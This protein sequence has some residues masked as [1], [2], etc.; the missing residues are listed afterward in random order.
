[1]SLVC[2]ACVAGLDELHQAFTQVRTGTLRDVGI[3]LAGGA[4]ALGLALAAAALRR[5][6]RGGA[7]VEAGP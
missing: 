7:P 1:V 6:L 3:D 5:V 4:A 2:V